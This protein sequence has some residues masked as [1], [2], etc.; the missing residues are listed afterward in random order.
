MATGKCY[1]RLQRAVRWHT[2]RAHLSKVQPQ[3]PSGLSGI[4]NYV[5]T[6]DNVHLPRKREALRTL[7]LRLNHDVSFIK[8]LRRQVHFA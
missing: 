3:M 7:P 5:F 4:E 2:L 1:C 8:R 6:F